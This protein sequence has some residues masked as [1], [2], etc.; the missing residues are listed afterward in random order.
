MNGIIPDEPDFETMLGG[1]LD[2]IDPIVAIRCAERHSSNLPFVQERGHA[3]LKVRTWD[4]AFISGG[5]AERKITAG[6]D[7]C[8]CARAHSSNG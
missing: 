7:I 5:F 6:V 8:A 3:S 2:V 4:K 1:A